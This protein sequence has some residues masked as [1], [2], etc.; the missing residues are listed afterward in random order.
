MNNWSP[1]KTFSQ[2][3]TLKSND[4]SIARLLKPKLHD[5]S[6]KMKTRAINVEYAFRFLTEYPNCS[7]RKLSKCQCCSLPNLVAFFSATTCIFPSMR[8]Y[9]WPAKNCLR[10]QQG[11][12][13]DGCVIAYMWTQKICLITDGQLHLT[14]CNQGALKK[15]ASVPIY[16]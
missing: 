15:T 7:P 11:I 16:Q 1:P 8:K 9:L 5:V 6:K 4:H 2:I 10:V 3:L 12:Q 14:A 13:N